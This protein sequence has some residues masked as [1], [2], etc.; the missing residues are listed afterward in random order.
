MRGAPS[1]V[2]AHPPAVRASPPASPSR[3][4]AADSA[5]LA[6][7]DARAP[8]CRR[9]PRTRAPLSRRR[10]VRQAAAHR[11]LGR[12]LAA[13][14]ERG[15]RCRGRPRPRAAR[16]A[17]PA[18]VR[19]IAQERQ[20]ST[21]TSAD[22]TGE[23]PAAARPMRLTGG[24]HRRVQ[25]LG[26]RR[27][28]GLPR[29]CPTRSHERSHVAQSR[30]RCGARHRGPTR[31]FSGSSRCP[32]GTVRTRDWPRFPAAHAPATEDAE[33]DRQRRPSRG[34]RIGARRE[35]CGWVPDADSGGGTLRS[36]HALARTRLRRGPRLRA[37]HPRRPLRRHSRRSP[38]APATP[39]SPAWSG[40]RRGSR[41][42]PSS[43]ERGRTRRPAVTSSPGR[44]SRRPSS[45]RGSGGRSPM[46]AGV[47]RPAECSE[48][49]PRC[50]AWRAAL[51]APA[52]CRLR[53]R[54][55]GRCRRRSP[56]PRPRCDFRPRLRRHPCA[57]RSRR[58]PYRPGLL[59]HPRRR[60]RPR[61]VRRRLPA[62]VAG[63]CL[64]GRAPRRTTTPSGGGAGRRRLL[65]LRPS[66]C[67]RPG[68]AALRPRAGRQ[69]RRPSNVPSMP[70]ADGG[71]P[72][73]R[74]THRAAH[75]PI[76]R[77]ASRA[78]R[79]RISEPTRAMRRPIDAVRITSARRSYPS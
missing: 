1:A 9:R 40:E 58:R 57:R 39:R 22:S 71:T 2:A 30:R 73:T 18:S 64:P 25:L 77:P 38:A 35:S 49:G 31:I 11:W 48:A 26:D 6:R 5:A 32:R 33:N 66:T 52:R 55:P 69:V 51:E 67:R 46:A 78:C 45:S 43:R 79:H 56:H 41:R 44:R 36:L 60:R 75:C 16:L 65:P 37:G 24:C 4:R 12:A 17:F 70:V 54:F 23:P 28:Q 21:D 13:S 15:L 29:R 50:R 62:G 19:A 68:P 42:K 47:C 7:P 27:P 74:R 8:G 61:G 53:H 63:R 34:H 20:C 3:A 76:T 72:S 10:S 59:L 14:V